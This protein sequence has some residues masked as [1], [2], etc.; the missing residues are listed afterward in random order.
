MENGKFN[1]EEYE[2]IKHRKEKLE[3]RVERDVP[4]YDRDTA[5]RLL[6]KV[7]QRL[8][9]YEQTHGISISSSYQH[10]TVVDDDISTNREDYSTSSSATYYQSFM[11]DFFD[12]EIHVYFDENEYYKNA[13]KDYFYQ[14]DV[15]S[16]EELIRDLGILYL[17]F[18]STYQTYLNYHVYRVRFLHQTEKEGAFARAIVN[19][20]EDDILICKEITIGFW[21]YHFGDGR[22]GDM[23]WAT[24]TESF[25]KYNNGCTLYLNKIL[26]E[27]QN[28]WNSYFDDD[29]FTK[30]IT[31]K[32]DSIEQTQM[33]D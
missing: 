12:I 9:Q 25:R 7:S 13:D 8:Q 5:I 17:I 31:L 29:I 1:Q 32:S 18:G 28:L 16:E 26:R 21:E 22:V 33:L 3:E 27:M 6:K 24:K 20:Y 30:K 23:E 2:R 10:H 19:I 11:K 14:K 4:G 15:R